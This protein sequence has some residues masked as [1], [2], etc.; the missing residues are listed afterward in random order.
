MKLDLHGIRHADVQRTL[1]VFFWQAIN[2]QQ[3]QVE[4]ICGNSQIMKDLVIEVCK[5]YRFTWNE[6]LLNKA[7]LFIDI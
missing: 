3:T 4:I 6:G 7:T 1:D 5:E 2:N